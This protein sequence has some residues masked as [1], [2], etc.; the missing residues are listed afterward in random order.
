V[1]GRLQ[2]KAFETIHLS[3]LYA[4]L[5]REGRRDGK[6]GGL[7]PRTVG[8]VHRA[9]HRMLKQAVRWNLIA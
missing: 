5:L 3:D 9:L 7:H 1:P 4:K 6:P 8:H 2:L